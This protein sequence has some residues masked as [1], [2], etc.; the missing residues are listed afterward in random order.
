MPFLQIAFQ[1]TLFGTLIETGTGFI[2]AVTGRIDSVFE[3]Q[4]KA[5]PVWIKPVLTA[6]LLIAGVFIAQFG[7]VGLIAKGYGTIT[8]GF[9]IFYVIPVLTIGIWKVRNHNITQLGSI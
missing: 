2:Y 3:E 4:K 7:L 8:W 1:I 6:A 9:F 5:V